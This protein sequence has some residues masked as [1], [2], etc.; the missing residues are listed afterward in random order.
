MR[1]LGQS[2]LNLWSRKLLVQRIQVFPSLYHGFLLEKGAHQNH[3]AQGL[4][5]HSLQQGK[6]CPLSIFVNK[7]LFERSHAPLH[8]SPDTTPELS[9]CNRKPV[10]CKAKIIFYL[11]FYRPS[12]SLF[13]VWSMDQQTHHLGTCYKDR[14]SGPTPNFL[15]RNLQF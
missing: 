7:V 13:K 5:N 9:S 4:A 14:I 10:I 15:E 8:S 11:G 2:F 1:N 6:S 12:F 3:H